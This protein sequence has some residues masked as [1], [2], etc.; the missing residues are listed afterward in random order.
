MTENWDIYAVLKRPRYGKLFVFSGPSGAG[1]TT[2]CRSLVARDRSLV[3][4]VS[5][6]TRP[7]RDDEVEDRDYRF[8]TP[9]AFEA[10]VRERGF[11]EYA[12]VHGHRYGT[13]RASLE[14]AMFAGAD[15]L[16]DIDVQGAAQ[17]REKYRDAVLAFV[18]PPS[19]EVLR[20]RLTSR[21][22]NDAADIE[23]RITQAE[24]ELA[25]ARDFHYFVINDRLEEAVAAAAAVI[26]A[27]RCRISK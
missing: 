26:K 1:K 19:R 13:A 12:E 9:A 10:L 21:G 15:V 16:L 23:R 27:E 22:Q 25:A 7:P 14:T 4:S 3:F 20:E 6:T 8:V 5:H 11:A 2:I 18:L 17:V 24:V